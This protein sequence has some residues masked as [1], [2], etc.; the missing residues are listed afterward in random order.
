MQQPQPFAQGTLTG[1]PTTVNVQQMQELIGALNNSVI[2]LGT[3]ARLLSQFSIGVAGTR[4]QLPMT[5]VALLPAVTAANAGSIA[6]ASNARN[7]GEGAGAGTGTLVEVNSAGTWL[8]V[9]S[10]VAPTT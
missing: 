7:V 5:T 6:W 1:P 3:I 4:L 8:S 9:W 10:G 2:A